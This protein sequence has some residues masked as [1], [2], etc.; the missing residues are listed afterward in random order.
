[1]VNPNSQLVNRR[2]FLGWLVQGA[3]GT[4]AATLATIAGG[5]IVVMRGARRRAEWIPAVALDT[6]S[7]SEPTEVALQV[8]RE[9][10]YRTTVDRRVLYLVK[11]GGR[12]RALSAV[13]THLGCRVAWHADRHEFRCPCHGGRFTRT[14]AVTGGPPPRGLDE[15]ET[16]VDAG[17]VFVRM[18]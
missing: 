9:D 17:R 1:M 13:C 8:E 10:G 6:V 11:D 14:G 4:I 3:L 7:T 12:V 2:R 5:A 18:A 15:V 16:R